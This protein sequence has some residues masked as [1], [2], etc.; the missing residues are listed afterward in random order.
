M[1][2]KLAG[3]LKLDRRSGTAKRAQLTLDMTGLAVYAVGDVHGCLDE[4]LRLERKIVTDA[5][6]VDAR[7]LIIMLGD[8]VDRGPASSQV[9]D[10]LLAPPPTGFERI[11]LTGNHELI[12]LEALHG[13][14]S[15]REWSDM[16]GAAALRSYGIDYHHLS[17]LCPPDE[18]LELIRNAIPPAHI[19]FLRSLPILVDSRDYLF[20]H[21][22]IR[23]E[24]D[25]EKQS[26]RDMVFI[27]S[28]FF[29]AAHL[30]KKWVVHGHTP[31]QQARLD[32]RRLNLDTGAYQ[33]GRL[34]AAR[35]WG[36]K[37]RILST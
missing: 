11:C 27:R 18:Q 25:L 9:I 24:V 29:N 7:K 30:L 36:N 33:T 3:F 16:G 1:I 26:D 6:D 12:M 22:G 23:P 4:L 17:R 20:V 31:V 2:K 34:S 37:G 19:A 10:H 8:Y 21:A 13:A 28:D 35:I 14:V 5:A 32:G 15:L